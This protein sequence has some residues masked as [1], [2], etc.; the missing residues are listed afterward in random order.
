MANKTWRALF[1]PTIAQ[2]IQDNKA[3]GEKA[4]KRALRAA[5]PGHIRGYWPEKVWYS[6]CRRQRDLAFRRG[7]GIGNDLPL[8]SN[9]NERGNQ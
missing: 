8:F 5:K 6:E 7:D 4:V 9:E 1:A 3:D 2:I